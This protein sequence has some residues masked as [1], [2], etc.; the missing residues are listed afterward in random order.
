MRQLMQWCSFSS[1]T[2]KDDE[3]Y[4]CLYA[5]KI[6][7]Q[8]VADFSKKK[9]QVVAERRDSDYLNTNK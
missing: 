9:K 2:G 8:V 6:S 7:Q 3:G 5:L 1:E 4:L